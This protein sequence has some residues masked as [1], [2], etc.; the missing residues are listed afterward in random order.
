MERASLGDVCA[1][2]SW[3]AVDN[4]A[5]ALI[6]CNKMIDDRLFPYLFWTFSL[7]SCFMG[8]HRKYNVSEPTVVK[9][10]P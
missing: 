10:I 1:L 4:R 8:K 7:Y 6:F 5:N 3:T 9:N 2:H